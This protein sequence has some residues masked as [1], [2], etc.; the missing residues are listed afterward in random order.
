M[1]SHFSYKQL[2]LVISLSMAGS[3]NAQ[4]ATTDSLS[5]LPV[6]TSATSST[7]DTLNSEPSAKG[8]TDKS[9]AKSA[10]K[11]DKTAT[12]E[13]KEDEDDKDDKDDKKKESS[14]ADLIEDMDIDEGYIDIYRDAETGKGLVVIDEAMLNTPVLYFAAT[15]N[16]VTEAGHFEGAY[17]SEKIIEF[18]RHFN[19]IDVVAINDDFYLDPNNAISKSKDANV[20][21]AILI[22]TDIKKNTEGKIVVDLDALFTNEAIHRVAPMPSRDPK[23]E[24]NRFKPGKLSKDKTRISTINNFPQNTHVVVDYVYENATPK[25]YGSNAVTDARYTTISLQHAL[26]KLPDND[27]LPRKDDARV[28]FFSTFKDD[29]TSASTTPFKDSINRWH[30]VKQDPSAAISDPVEPIVWWIENTTPLEWRETITNAALAWN[31]SFEQAGF[32]NAV[33]VKQQPDDADWTA[34]DVRYNVLR[35]TSS[36]NPPFGGYGPSLVNPLNGQIIAADIMLEYSFLSGRWLAGQ[37]LSN[38]FSDVDQATAYFDEQIEHRSAEQ[39]MHCSLGHAI[40]E[41]V[42]LSQALGYGELGDINEE[43]LLR[44][45]MHYLILHEIGHTLGLNHNMRASQLHDHKA[46]H[47]ISVTKGI[48]AGSVMDYPAVNYA[49]VGMQQGDFYSD[50]PGPY[51]DWAITYGYS[52][53]D[54]DPI[55]EA[56]R[57]EALLQRSSEAELAFGNDADDM[58]SPGKAID[59][60]VNIFDMSSNAVG[61]AQDRFALVQDAAKN[62]KSALLVDGKSHNDL[63]AAANILLNEMSR[64]AAVVSRYIGGVYVERN[65]VGQANYVQ[66]FTPAPKAMQ[67]AA[68]QTLQEHVFAPDVLDNM[69]PLLAFLQNQRR[70]FSH[71]SRTEDPKPHAFLIRMQKRVFDHVL[72]PNVL[73]RITDSTK[74]GNTYPIETMLR[75]LTNAVF[76]AD[77]KKD[78]NSYRR[79]LQVEYVERLINISGLEKASK[80]DRIAQATALFELVHIQEL[81]D[82]RRGDQATKVHKFYLNDR[83]NRARH[84]SK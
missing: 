3:I 22:T 1:S 27:Y 66:P 53:A 42:L 41:G 5:L 20:S 43:E 55:A 65:V 26:V 68:M 34:D 36:P 14:F 13:S 30:L 12:K 8:E 62:I 64:Q 23:R 39:G 46:A 71:Y 59:P 47:D 78:V 28:G 54:N 10:K 19:K 77:I 50:K 31:S 57:L 2:A 16:G 83:I 56:A 69:E 80:Y 4:A 79:H 75:D 17:R 48:L 29:L 82:S 67:T 6:I 7:V 25:N 37:I 40:N 52:Q 58:R 24:K 32:S 84:K 61:Y 21:E 9:T 45:S 74:Y 49:P 73:A 15:V 72:H 70:G 81:A 35:W 11:S 38:G 33:V 63:V 18:R 51:D 76:A 60:R 44:Q